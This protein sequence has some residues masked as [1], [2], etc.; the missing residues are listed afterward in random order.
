MKRSGLLIVIGAVIL[1][2][3]SAAVPLTRAQ[4]VATRLKFYVATNGSDSNPGTLDRPWRTIQKAANTVGAGSTVYVRGGVYNETVT[5]NVSGTP[6][7]VI[8]F[9]SSSTRQRSST[10]AASPR[11]MAGRR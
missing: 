11:P 3:L 9:Q 2:V 8:T 6:G 10:A 1:L 5:I 4:E 7:N